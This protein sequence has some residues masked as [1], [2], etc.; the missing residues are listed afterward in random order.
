MFWMD[1]LIKAYVFLIGLIIGSYLNVLIYRIP[2]KISTSKGFSFC[3]KCNHRLSWLDLFPLFSYVFL[4]AKCRYCKDS[5]SFRY[6]AIESLN[7]VLYF[8]VYLKFAPDLTSSTATQFSVL[9]DMGVVA[10]YFLIISS[11][12]VLTFIDIDHKII[13]DRFHIIIGACA[14]A[15]IFL[16]N[17][18]TIWERIIGFFAISVP[19]YIIALLTN[20]MGEGDVKLF[21]VCG[22][23]L[24]WKL[25]LLTML[26]ASLIAA[27]YGLILIVAKKAKG[28]SEIPFGP[29]I[30]FA[31]TICIFVGNDII[32]LYISFITR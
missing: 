26:I 28:K 7:A 2:L 17:D 20:G 11:L 24:G 13:P 19:I 30:A 27:V 29:F 1:V 15:L 21:A 31:V 32:N 4:G 5:I 6:P 9:T 12:V 22:L 3:P 10:I 23:L 25:I 14:I 8:L 16:T 18:L